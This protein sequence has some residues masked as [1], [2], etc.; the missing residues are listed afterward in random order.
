MGEGPLAELGAVGHEYR[1]VSGCD[2]RLLDRHLNEVDVGDARLRMDRLG[3][4]ECPVDVQAGKAVDGKGPDEG[5]DG[6]DPEAAGDVQAVRRMP[7]RAHTHHQVIG[8]HCEVALSPQR[9]GYLVHRRTT[10]DDHAL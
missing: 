2:H 1:T 9:T 3:S 4:D 6:V 10:V 8:D 5:I 7:G